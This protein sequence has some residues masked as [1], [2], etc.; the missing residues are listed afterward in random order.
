MTTSRI[1]AEH[2]P[3]RMIRTLRILAFSA[4]LSPRC[5]TTNW[6]HRRDMLLNLWWRPLTECLHRDWISFD[7][8]N[9]QKKALQKLVVL[10]LINQNWKFLKIQ[11]KIVIVNSIRHP[12][13]QKFKEWLSNFRRAAVSYHQS[14]PG[15][16]M[17]ISV[18][19]YWKHFSVVS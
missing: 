12:C 9:K 4:T 17:M 19:V 13:V 15:V 14:Y 1:W 18:H 6:W 10:L 11:F 16:L 2:D 5:P 8:I 3:W 7:K